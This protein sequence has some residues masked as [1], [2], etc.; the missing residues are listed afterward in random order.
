M[1]VV[2]VGNL[3]F[4]IYLKVSELPGPDENVE[5][6]D[7]YTGGGGS[8]ANFSVA[9]ARLGLGVRFIGAVGEDPLGELSLR[10]LRSE[11]VDVSYVKRVA[12]VRS[13]VVIV[14]VHPDGVKRMLSYRGANLGLSP[15]DL[16]I[17]KFRGFRHIHLATGRTELIL[18]AKEIAK[19]IG[20]TVS[21][22]GGT[23]LAK[24]GLD[25]V[26]AVVNGIDIVFMNQVEAKLLANSHDHKTAVEKLAKE[27]SVRELVVTLG[28]RGAV[29]FDGRRL[30]HVDAF[31]LDAV[32]TTGAGDCF[33]AAYVAMYLRGRD[34]YEKLLF[35]NAAAAIKVTRPGARSSPR[36]SEVVAF[37]E[38]LGYKI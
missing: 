9:A 31:K 11:G 29:A 19:E 17:E 34:L 37:L 36:Y 15:A 23:A 18:K 6:L 35:A 1:D 2:S 10:E 22:D 14:L 4:D 30:L 32:D 5:V 8:A 26:K 7:L 20:A 38:S 24:K 16:T 12:G 3:N 21:L 28:P 33:A 25:I 13:G 27:L